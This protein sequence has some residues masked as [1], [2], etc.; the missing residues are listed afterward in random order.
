MESKHT[1]GTLHAHGEQIDVIYVDG[2][3]RHYILARA[4]D[5]YDDYSKLG[6]DHDTMMANAAR[7]AACWNACVGI[8]PAAVPKLLAVVEDLCRKHPGGSIAFSLGL[9]LERAET[10]LV[11]ALAG[12]EPQDGQ[13]T[14]QESP[15]T[16]D[17]PEIDPG[18]AE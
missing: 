13:G 16:D 1:P 11:E 18:A 10:A 3:E 12:Q 9:L 8:N 14:P 15:V 5:H 4:L 17:R 7:L 6:I 2:H